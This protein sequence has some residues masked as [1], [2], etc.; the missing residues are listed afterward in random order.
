MYIMV[1][2]PP[3]ARASA[4][5]AARSP[6]LR[7]DIRTI[8]RD[9]LVHHY[10]GPVGVVAVHVFCFTWSGNILVTS[11]PC[12]WSS[13]VLLIVLDSVWFGLMG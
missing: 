5:V 12:V 4:V 1:F 8:V 2:A 9:W 11:A 13:K 6:R 3:W 7:P 10:T